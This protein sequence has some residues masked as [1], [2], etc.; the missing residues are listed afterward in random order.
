M[1]HKQRAIQ[2][3]GEYKNNFDL[4]LETC[5]KRLIIH[6]IKIARKQ[7]LENI[8]RKKKGRLFW[9]NNIILIQQTWLLFFKKFLRLFL[10]STVSILLVIFEIFYLWNCFSCLFSVFVTLLE[11][12]S[13]GSFIIAKNCS[14]DA[15]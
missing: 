3:L 9:G 2:L 6:M 4:T 1:L 5:F 14:V 15:N 11:C 12:S 7:L 10:F 13:S 8:L